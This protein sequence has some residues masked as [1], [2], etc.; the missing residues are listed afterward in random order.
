MRDWG[1]LWSLWVRPAGF[2]P[3][4][5]ACDLTSLCVVGVW[6]D[7]LAVGGQG[8][9]G[10]FFDPLGRRCSAMRLAGVQ[11][12]R[13]V[14]VGPEVNGVGAQEPGATHDDASGWVGQCPAE[15]GVT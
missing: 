1:P 6:F 11:K 15:E 8:A 4:A 14:R 10:R 2:E 3:A 9:F 12:R 13:V 5:L 7:G